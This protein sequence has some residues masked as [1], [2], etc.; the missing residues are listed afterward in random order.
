MYDDGK[1][2]DQEYHDILFNGL[3]FTF[4]KYVENIQYPYFVFY[5]KEYLENTY[6][7]DLDITNGLRVYT[8]IDPELQLKAEDIVQR[9]VEV[10]KS[11][12][13][14]SSAALVS[15]DNSNGH[16]LAMVGGPNYYDEE[17]G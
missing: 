9:Q 12:Y 11:K 4:Q 8:T 16:I 2:T 3:E 6:G 17:N 10:G 7:N 1:I 13:N 5:I 14:V 15:M